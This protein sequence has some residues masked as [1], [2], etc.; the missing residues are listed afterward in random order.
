MN[1]FLFLSVAVVLGAGCSAADVRPS[2]VAGSFYERA[3]FALDRQIDALLKDGLR[4]VT[5]GQLVAAVV[6]H[7]GYVFSGPCAASLYSGIS[8]GQ[9]DRIIILC[10]A[11]HLFVAGVSLPDPS[12]MG[13]ATPLGTVEI[14]RA[15]CDTLT[16]KK[17]FVV[18]PEAAVREH[19]IEVQLPLLQKTARTFK[20]VPLICGPPG[21]VDVDAVSAALAPYLGERTL[22][23]ASS[24]FTHFGPNYG[25]EPFTDRIPDRLREWL[26]LASGRI[27]ALDEKG[28]KAHCDT[29]HDS[30]C[31]EIP[32]RIMMA[33]LNRSTLKPA[34]RV[35][36]LS[37]SG[38]K[39]G[40]YRNSVSY[41]AI[42]FYAVPP[43]VAALNST[44]T[45]AKE[46]ATVK[47][48]RSGTWT[49][50]L[51]EAEKTA[52]F[53]IARDTLKW[54]VTGRREPFDYGR[55][56]LTPLMKAD[57]ATFVTLK[58]QGALRGCIGSLVPAE[59]LYVSVHDN[60]VN[61]A[62]RDPR[63]RP[64]EPEELAR[65]TVDVSVLSPIRDIA[66]VADFK[67]GQQGIILEKGRYRAVYLPEVATEQ[68]WTVEET[69]A[70]LSEKAGLPA[71]AWREGAR[72]KVFE[73]VV[74]SE[75]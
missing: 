72:F 11:H 48:H 15:V 4:P 44:G 5:T 1:R 61:A 59:P 49:P 39:T 73:S 62:L 51:S 64:V 14:D 22:L 36:G 35:I 19:A 65:I 69:L 29:S 47:E 32:I 60:A 70:S 63:F 23:L 2:A 30:I 67:I 9:Y 74:L 57:T 38:E 43:V 31:G 50:G 20:L 17:G 42:G 10:P 46:G 27:A 56:T 52:L 21:T 3:P 41:A 55:Y 45:G 28:F 25:F 12:L 18:V 8:S 71:D 54:C 7:A 24:D 34:G 37:S 68:G 58:L 40:D 26:T 75:P 6:P 53:A 33:A 13:Y 16:K 66:S